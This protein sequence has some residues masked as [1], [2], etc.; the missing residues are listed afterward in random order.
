MAMLKN[1]LHSHLKEFESPKEALE[2]IN[3]ILYHDPAINTFVPLFYGIL[4]TNSLTFK[5][6]NAGHEPALA[7]CSNS[8][9]TLDTKGFPIGAFE[10]VDFEEKEIQLKDNSLHIYN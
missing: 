8:F 4:D 7:L 6:T 5:Y 2:K 10:D 1:I 3:S 9:K